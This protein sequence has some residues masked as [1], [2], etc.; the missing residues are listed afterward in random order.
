MVIDSIL[1]TQLL[2]RTDL[3]PLLHQLLLR[4]FPILFD[5]LIL[6]L[7]EHDGLQVERVLVAL[8]PLVH[9]ALQPVFVH[10]VL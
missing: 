5:L 9:V 6:V 10:L 3:T 2:S 7:L 1:L 4:L 8:A